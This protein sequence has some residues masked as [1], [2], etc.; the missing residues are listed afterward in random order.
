[1]VRASYNQKPGRRIISQLYGAEMFP[2]PSDQTDFGRKLLAENPNHNG[3]LGIAISEAVEDCL[4]NDDTRYTL[5]S[6][7]NHVAMHQ[8]IIGLEA[9]KQFA[10]IDT[11]PDVI[12]GC[13]GG[14]S[15]FA[16]FSFPFMADKL[17][18]KADIDFIACESKAVPHTTRGVYTYDYGDTAAT[19]PIIKMLTIGHAYTCPPIHAGGLRYHGMSPLVSY[20][21]YKGYIRSKAFGQTEIFEA[22]RTLAQ[23]EGLVIAPETAHALRCT[24]D[25]A[26]ACKK[27]GQKK[28]IAMN[29][30]G[31]GLL[32]ISAYEQFFSGK[33]VDYEPQKIEV[34]LFEP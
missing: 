26:L 18:G 16:G 25:E 29:Y 8:T 17:K 6:V 1:M 13:V 33:L 34:P 22:A 5:G 30:S 9:Q 20:L 11:K 24:I 28:V 14:G 21:I 23:T 19:A 2:S 10:I 7:L 12:I 31:H 3:S 27:T 32:D 4:K 15:N